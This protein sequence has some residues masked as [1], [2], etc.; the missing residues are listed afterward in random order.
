MRIDELKLTLSSD[1]SPEDNAMQVFFDVIASATVNETP[2]QYDAN[3]QLVAEASTEVTDFAIDAVRE[4]TIS[5]G[6]FGQMMPSDTPFASMVDVEC[7][8]RLDWLNSVLDDNDH[9]TDRIKAAALA[10][11]DMA[12]AVY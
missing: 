9:W 12:L 1:P 6:R 7:Q 10:K 3:G 5:F 2:D 11:Y 8:R 4:M